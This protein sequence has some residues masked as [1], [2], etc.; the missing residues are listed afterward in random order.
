MGGTLSQ[1]VFQ[2]PRYPE[3]PPRD[4]DF[5]PLT[6]KGGET[7]QSLHIKGGDGG[8]TLLYSH[9]NA[10]DISAAKEYFKHLA[11]LCRVDV[12]L[13]DYVGY[14]CSSGKPS[15]RGVY[16]SIEA[17]FEYL[18]Q[19]LHI[20][21]SNIIA[22]G[23]S[24]GSGPS[25]HLCVHHELGGL[26][27]QSAL[28]SIHRVALQL[29]VSLPF[30]MFVNK[31]K[32]GK[33]KCPI[34]CIHGT[35][36]EVVPLSHG[37]GLGSAIV[38]GA[39]QEGP[40]EG[41]PLLGGGGG[42]QQLGGDGE[43][44]LFCGPQTIFQ[45]CDA[46]KLSTAAAAAAGGQCCYGAGLLAWRPLFLFLEVKRQERRQVSAS[47]LTA[48]FSESERLAP[49]QRETGKKRKATGDGG[50]SSCRR[51][52]LSRNRHACSL[53]T[54]AEPHSKREETDMVFLRLA[55]CSS[56]AQCKAAFGFLWNYPSTFEKAQEVLAHCS[57]PFKC[58]TQNQNTC[59]VKKT[60]SS[61]STL[62]MQQQRV[63]FNP[64]T[65]SRRQ[66][67]AARGCCS[68]IQYIPQL[69]KVVPHTTQGGPLLQSTVTAG[70]PPSQ[71]GASA[72]EAPT[73]LKHE[74]KGP[75]KGPPSVW[76][77]SAES[78]VFCAVGPPSQGIMRAPSSL[79]M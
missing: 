63:Q 25:V 66:E 14:G 37:I 45:T 38:A 57:R 28:L 76:L 78:S 75:H 44:T 26:I 13:F 19:K 34:F 77:K 56:H 21:P 55:N 8:L 59:N 60:N 11:A 64:N 2:P 47:T 67:T 41:E 6:T 73:L 10:E 62:Y 24:L 79:T 32:I 68:S 43:E 15:E 35:N 42:P 31:D 3:G 5:I 17:A 71:G 16:E 46:T 20:H 51:A 69:D 33:V 4:A 12:F 1:I 50:W 23:R 9:G 18:T 70:H 40:P 58:L 29:R 61:S 22:Y 74:L 48:G 49:R 36:D 7:I 52:M 53:A 65:D 30:D 72:L 54:A 39:V 27:L